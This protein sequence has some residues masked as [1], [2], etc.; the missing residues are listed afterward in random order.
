MIGK[1]QVLDKGYVALHEVLG[2]DLTPVN[3]AKVSFDKASKE[4]GPREERLINFLADHEHT[5]PFRHAILQFEAY[6]PLM[7]ARQWWKYVIGSGHKEFDHMQDPFLAWNESSR[8]Y[9]TEQPEFYVV[10][11]GEWRSAP[12]NN[13]QGSGG[14]VPLVLGLKWTQELINTYNEGLRKYEEAMSNGICAEQAR[15]FLPAYGLY[16]RWYWTA[17]LQGVSHLLTQRLANDAQKEFQF[18]AGAVKELAELKF[19]IALKALLQ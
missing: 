3:S 13:K 2:S 6:A 1:I 15:L 4:V 7:V 14:S 5:S 12:E 16:V 10:E 9:I 8:R 17:S 11:P 19:P 18:F